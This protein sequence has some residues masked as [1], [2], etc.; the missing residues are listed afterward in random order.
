ME[1]PNQNLGRGYFLKF[2]SYHIMAF[3][4]QQNSDESKMVDGIDNLTRQ[5]HQGNVVAIVKLLNEHLSEKEVRVRGIFVNGILQLLCEATD[6]AALEQLSLLENIQNLLEKLTPYH[7][8]QVNVYSRIRQEGQLLW[9]EEITRDLDNTVLWSQSFSLTPPTFWNQ[10]Q[11]DWSDLMVDSPQRPLLF[12]KWGWIAVVIFFLMGFL[13]WRFYQNFLSPS[14]QPVAL[15]PSPPPVPSPSSSFTPSPSS[16]SSQDAFV[17]AVR[18]AQ[19][20]V[21][22]GQTASNREDWLKI[23]QQWLE[24]SQLMEK[25]T[26]DYPR[27]DIAQDRAS[28]YYQNSQ[29]AQ[30]EAD[31]Y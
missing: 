30:Q 20:A 19:E 25:V 18:L 3:I 9:L 29:N 10:I 27:Y 12:W 4:I 5:A 8:H 11:E 24:A 26:S 23:S 2:H 1:T 13:G 6:I 28:L 22:A 16:L 14:P 31:K 7:I 21:K 17:K 15:P